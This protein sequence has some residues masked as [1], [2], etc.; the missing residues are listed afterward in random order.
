[1]V[2][3]WIVGCLLALPGLAACA[4]GTDDASREGEIEGSRISQQALKGGCRVVCPKCLPNQP[5]PKYAC[6]L[7]CPPK[8]TPCGDT[9]CTGGDVC[10]NA[11]CGICTPPGGACIQVACE[12]TSTCNMLGLCVEGFVWDSV[13]CKCVPDGSSDPECTTDA[14]CRLED[15]YCG[16]CDCLALSSNESGPTCTDPVQCFAQPCGFGQVAACVAGECVIQ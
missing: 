5:C 9:V 7:K 3:R 2:R 13:A 4:V 10:C 12:P 8:V 15:N 14:D 6:Y 1:M 11:S 16:G